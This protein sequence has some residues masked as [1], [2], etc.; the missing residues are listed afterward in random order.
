MLPGAV[1]RYEVGAS[2]SQTAQELRLRVIAT[3]NGF[4]LAIIDAV[5]PNSSVQPGILFTVRFFMV[6]NDLTVVQNLTVRAEVSNTGNNV[7]IN[8]EFKITDRCKV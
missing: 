5:L 8:L 7:V 1:Y 3:N 4:R 2:S 6:N